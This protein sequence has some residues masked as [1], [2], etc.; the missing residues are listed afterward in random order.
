MK[1]QN[2]WNFKKVETPTFDISLAHVLLVLFQCF[3]HVLF[4]GDLD[5][6]FAGRSAF[7]GQS[8]MNTCIAVFEFA[9]REEIRDLID[10]R[11]PRQSA[12]SNNISIRVVVRHFSSTFDVIM[13]EFD[14]KNGDPSFLPNFL[15]GFRRKWPIAYEKRRN[16]TLFGAEKPKRHNVMMDRN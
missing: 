15:S 8:E 12:A 13:I 11:G 9:I 14:A 16:N 2:Q 10:G 6:G 4:A 5:V 7:S 1:R 3:F